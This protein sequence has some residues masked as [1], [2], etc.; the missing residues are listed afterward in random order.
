MPEKP[1][2]LRR[3]PMATGSWTRSFHCRS[4]AAEDVATTVAALPRKSHLLLRSSCA[5]SGDIHHRNN[6]VASCKPKLKSSPKPSPETSKKKPKDSTKPTSSVLPSPSPPPPGPLGPL[7]ALTELPAGHSSRQVVEIIFLS[8]WSPLP[9]APPAAF[10]GEVEMLFRVHNQARA[11]ARFEDYRAA[12]RARARDARSAADGN[13]MMR[14][15]PAPAHGCSSSDGAAALRVVRTFD[16]SGGAHASGRGFRGPESS[17][18]RA[19]FLC[20]VIAGRVAEGED[21][22]GKDEY[23]SVRSGKG[24]LVVFD[25]R[26]VLPCFLIIYKL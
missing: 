17:G 14:F 24:E 10:T 26:A 21:Q 7:P 8:S 11:V 5:S 15:S 2:P 6:N 3:R 9:P 18:R 20:R 12:V 23:D 4:T 19:M 1:P 25:R 13:E 22:S 16:G